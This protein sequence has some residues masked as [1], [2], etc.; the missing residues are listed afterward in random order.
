MTRAKLNLRAP[1]L[2]IDMPVL[3]T[4]FLIDLQRAEQR[5]VAAFRG[6]QGQDLVVPMVVAKEFLA[7]FD[8]PLAAWR[9]LQQ[10]YTV[11][12]EGMDQAIAASRIFRRLRKAGRRAMWNDATVA[13]HAELDATFVV[14]GDVKDFE[15]MGCQVWD[16]RKGGAPPA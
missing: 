11:G 15:A 14:T 2:G 7:G 6:L 3:D 8:E 12:V 4:S 16:Y 10:E 9:L 13:A 1:T 5:A